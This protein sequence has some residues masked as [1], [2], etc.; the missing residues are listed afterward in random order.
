MLKN[1]T[2]AQIKAE[3]LSELGLSNPHQVPKIEKIIIG[4][5]VGTLAQKD[6]KLVKEV[7]ENLTLIAGQ[8]AVVNKARK[9]IS[10]FKLRST[11]NL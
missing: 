9:S 10:N 1:I 11:S 4:A 6:K 8:K 3:L 5:G 2:Q 7:Q